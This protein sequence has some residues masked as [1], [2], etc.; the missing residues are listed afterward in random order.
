[1][2]HELDQFKDISCYPCLPGTEVECR[3][4]TQERAGLNTAIPFFISVTEFSENTEEKLE[5]HLRC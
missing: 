2:K 4:L 5:C 3:F 1:M